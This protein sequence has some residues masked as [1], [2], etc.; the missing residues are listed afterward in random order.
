MAGGAASDAAGNHPVADITTEADTENDPENLL[1][2]SDGEGD[3]GKSETPNKCLSGE[4]LAPA[5]LGA[6]CGD[7][8][9]QRGKEARHG[10]AVSTEGFALRGREGGFF[11]EDEA[12]VKEQQAEGHDEPAEAAGEK[13][14]SGGE[15]DPAEIKRIARPA[16]GAVGDELFGMERVVVDHHAVEIRSGPSAEQRGEEGEER[17]EGEKETQLGYGS[18]RIRNEGAAQD[19]FGERDGGVFWVDAVG[20]ESRPENSADEP[21]ACAKFDFGGAHHEGS[22]Q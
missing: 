12:V 19:D 4:G 1:A 18:G 10:G 8:R 7:A 9:T 2:E 15:K 14:D 22:D 13:S 3:D 17:A 16:E 20:S 21:K 6:A 11:A 5:R